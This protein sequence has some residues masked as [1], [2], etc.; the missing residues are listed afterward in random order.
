M[1]QALRCFNHQGRALPLSPPARALLHTGILW[2]FC[3]FV[4]M[5]IFC[6]NKHEGKGESE[7]AELIT[8]RDHITCLILILKWQDTG[9]LLVMFQWMLAFTV[10]SNF[11]PSYGSDFSWSIS[12]K[13]IYQS[14]E[15]PAEAKSSMMWK[16]WLCLY[17]VFSCERTEPPS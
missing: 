16:G 1:L 12:E 8:K 17:Y 5:R 4:C 13:K 3:L 9:A 11:F 10:P 2:L 14:K 6:A 7:R 15:C